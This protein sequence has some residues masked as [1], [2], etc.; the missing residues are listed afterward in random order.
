MEGAQSQERSETPLIG[1]T[2]GDAC[3]VVCFRPGDY[4]ASECDSPPRTI[5]MPRSKRPDLQPLIGSH[6]PK[7]LIFSFTVLGSPPVDE[8]DLSC[9]SEMREL[10]HLTIRGAKSI[11]DFSP[12]SSCKNLK[13]IEIVQSDYSVIDLSPLTD[14]PELQSIALQF[15]YRPAK[16]ILPMLDHHPHMR[17]VS[18]NTFYTEDLSTVYSE[19]RNIP[20]HARTIIDLAPLC[21]CHSL[22]VLNLRENPKLASL[23][24]EPLRDLKNLET[25]D[26]SNNMIM[27]FDWDLRPLADCSGLKQLIIENKPIYAVGAGEYDYIYKADWLDITPLF[28]IDSLE[29]LVVAKS[30][31]GS[32]SL[33]D[34]RKRR[35]CG[36]T[37][38]TI[39]EHKGGTEGK[40]GITGFH[41]FRANTGGC[42]PKLVANDRIVPASRRS[43]VWLKPYKVKWCVRRPSRFVPYY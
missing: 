24:L 37:Y 38:E 11:P 25:L 10:E 32:F 4:L 30:D 17:S 12:L 42:Y 8:I 39:F 18:I 29:L 7:K 43:P 21:N 40:V 26:L 20:K 28:E 41:L 15:N 36:W 6:R 14:C 22:R 33:D 31:R 13:T 27:Y 23:K 5:L 34:P 35:Y 16:I 9:V 2:G 3:E 19:K 1:N